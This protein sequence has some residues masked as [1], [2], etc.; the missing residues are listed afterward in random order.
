MKITFN[1]PVI[2]GFSFLSV[3][4]FVLT[5]YLGLAINLFT[6]PGHFEFNNWSNYPRL[7]SYVL[8]HS[9]ADH[10][11]GNLSFILLLGPI[12][13]EKYGS[14]NTLIMVL[15]TAIIT[16]I[17][18]LLFF[19]N[20]L[21]GVSGIV[22]SFIVLVSLV[23]FRNNEIP[24]T[25]ILVA[26]IFIGKELIHMFNDD[27]ISQFA[28][29]LGGCIGAVFG[30]KLKSKVKGSKNSKTTDILKGLK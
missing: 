16:A 28:H 19:S 13:E 3:L 18:H 8:G 30:F 17:F 10:I 26:I 20:G 5:Q 2:L 1:S 27:S 15:T 29:I 4:V 12:I 25:F 11:I 9:N 22:F 6:L 23:N 24:I 21:L 7:F 14:K